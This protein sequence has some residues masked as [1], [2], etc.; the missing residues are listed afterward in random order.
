MNFTVRSPSLRTKINLD[1]N[2]KKN[3]VVHYYNTKVFTSSFF[4]YRTSFEQKIEKKQTKSTWNSLKLPTSTT[5]KKNA[6]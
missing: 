6:V 5:A 4:S 1:I 2:L 3:V